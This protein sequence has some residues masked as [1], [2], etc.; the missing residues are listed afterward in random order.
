MFS[1]SVLENASIWMGEKVL[2][3]SQFVVS[4]WRKMNV[5]CIN[6]GSVIQWFCIY[7]IVQRSFFYLF[8]SL[9]SFVYSLANQTF[10]K[11]NRTNQFV[12]ETLLKIMHPWLRQNWQVFFF[13]FVNNSKDINFLTEI[14]FMVIE[15]F[16]VIHI[17]NNMQ[18]L[19]RRRKI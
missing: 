5:P 8:K 7:G 18:R 2:D 9:A 17:V 14:L 15:A 13:Y 1:S 11:K 6:I 12:R 10:F 19:L 3:L 4:R 16:A